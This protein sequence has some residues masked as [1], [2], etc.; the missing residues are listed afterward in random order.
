M[1]STNEKRLST[2]VQAATGRPEVPTLATLNYRVAQVFKGSTRTQRQMARTT[3]RWRVE[4]AQGQQR[5]EMLRKMADASLTSV[6]ADQQ[7]RLE[8]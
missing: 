7:F 8:A 1:R 4:I 2:C 6:R 5:A 3:A